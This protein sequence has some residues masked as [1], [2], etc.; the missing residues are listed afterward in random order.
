M[1]VLFLHKITQGKSEENQSRRIRLLAGKILEI[2]AKDNGAHIYLQEITVLRYTRKLKTNIIFCDTTENIVYFESGSRCKNKKYKCYRWIRKTA[3][4][5]KLS[6]RD[7]IIYPGIFE[8][9]NQSVII[10]SVQ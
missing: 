10:C 3:G 5:W 7:W 2:T 4:R 6:S 9:S 1:K 8:R